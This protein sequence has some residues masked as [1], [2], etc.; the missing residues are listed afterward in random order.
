VR[1]GSGDTVGAVVVYPPAKALGRK[2]ALAALVPL[3]NT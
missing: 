2:K 1:K 3:P